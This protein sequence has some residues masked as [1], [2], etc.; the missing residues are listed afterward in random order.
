MYA[1]ATVIPY[2]ESFGSVTQL[3]TGR[4]IP[5]EAVKE[6]IALSLPADFRGDMYADVFCISRK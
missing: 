6:G 1:R 3:S 5:A 4:A 2:F